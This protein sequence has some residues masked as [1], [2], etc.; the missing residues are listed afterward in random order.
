MLRCRD[1][2]ANLKRKVEAGADAVF[3]QLFYENANFFRFREC[4]AKAG[5]KV[6][7]IP[8]IMPITEF[9][10]IKRITQMCG[11]VFP[12][13]LASRLEAVQEDKQAQ[14]QIGVEHAIPN[15]GNSI[16]QGVPGLHFYV[17]NKSKACEE[18]LSGLDIAPPKASSA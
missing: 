12:A 7:L 14:Y 4:Y 16:A 11:A 1:R 8:G 3:T 9:A 5:I 18:I 15:A 6:P 10:R 17:L 2:S 13:D